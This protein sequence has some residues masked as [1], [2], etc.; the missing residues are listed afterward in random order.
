MAL[1]RP[2]AV[3]GQHGTQEKVGAVAGVDRDRREKGRE[4]LAHGFHQSAHDPGDVH[5]ARERVAVADPA[6]Q[7]L[8]GGHRCRPRDVAQ[9][10]DLADDRAGRHVLDGHHVVIGD[11]AN[12]GRAGR[13]QQE[14]DRLF[15]LRHQGLAGGGPQRLQAGRQWH[16]V[17]GGTAVE[18]VQRGEFVGA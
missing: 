1:Q 13:D 2:L 6:G 15:A 3:T 11:V 18:D 17:L 16:Q 14:G 4:P 10:S 5:Q 12:L 9:E 7:Q 8:G